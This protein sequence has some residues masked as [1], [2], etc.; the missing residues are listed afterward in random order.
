[1]GTGAG[2]RDAEEGQ[3]QGKGGASQCRRKRSCRLG[4][5]KEP[6]SLEGGL[7]WRTWK[8]GGAEG[9]AWAS[10]ATQSRCGLSKRGRSLPPPGL[11]A[12]VGFSGTFPAPRSPRQRPSPPTSHAVSP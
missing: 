2:V 4:V 1:M 3:A 11:D 10:E 9:L 5:R 6:Y 8:G 12:N 7:G